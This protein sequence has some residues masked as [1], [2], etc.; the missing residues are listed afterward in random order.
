MR[1]TEDHYNI[2]STV[3]LFTPFR[4]QNLKKKLEKKKIG[5]TF[6]FLVH[7]LLTISF[8]K[9]KLRHIKERLY[10]V[11][12]VWFCTNDSQKR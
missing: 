5:Q 8:Y 1:E 10:T 6:L 11:M 3:K 12:N 9:L 2:P 4:S 7:T